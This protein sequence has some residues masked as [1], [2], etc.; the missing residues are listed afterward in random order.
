MARVSEREKQEGSGKGG[1]R[2]FTRTT[3]GNEIE[4]SNTRAS[5]SLR[6]GGGV[7]RKEGG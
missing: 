5:K 2:G 6:L 4:E 1:R 3:R 7:R